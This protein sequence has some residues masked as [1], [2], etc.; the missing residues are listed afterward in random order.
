MASQLTIRIYNQMRRKTDELFP[1]SERDENIV[2]RNASRFERISAQ[3]L[4]GPIRPKV[5]CVM[6]KRSCRRRPKYGAQ[7]PLYKTATVASRAAASRTW[8]KKSTN[9]SGR[10]FQIQFERPAFF[11]SRFKV[12]NK[13]AATKSPLKFFWSI[14]EKF[15]RINK[16][17]TI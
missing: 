12:I 13:K 3:P 16:K 10:T 5:V 1:Q 15:P 6:S 14:P 4:R 11:I 8:A 17:L 7:K 2:R 9:K